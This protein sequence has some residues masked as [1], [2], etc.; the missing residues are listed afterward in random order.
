MFIVA[1]M[2]TLTFWIFQL[3]VT[4]YPSIAH[5]PISGV[6]YI[7]QLCSLEWAWDPTNEDGLSGINWLCMIHDE[8]TVRKLPWSDLNLKE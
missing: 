7:C 3:W 4:I 6:E 1:I 5:I 2:L 8:I